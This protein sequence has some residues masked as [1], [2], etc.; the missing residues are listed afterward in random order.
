MKTSPSPKAT[1]AGFTLI[2]LLTVIAIIS[3]LAAMLLPALSKAKA[4]AQGIQC[5]NNLRQLGLAWIM[6]ADDHQG[7]LAPSIAAGHNSGKVPRLDSWVGGAM[8]FDSNFDNVNTGLLI[9][10]GTY[11]HAAKLGPYLKN[12]AIFRC[13]G[14]KSQVEI[15]GRMVNRVRS[16]AMNVYMGNHGVNPNE[17][18]SLWF[19]SQ[20]QLFMRYSDMANPAKYYVFIDEREDSINEG[21]FGVVMEAEAMGDWPASY[22][23]NGGALAFGDGHSELKKWLDPRTRPAKKN[24]GKLDQLVLMPGSS[25]LAWL[26]ERSTSPR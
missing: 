9:D 13:P 5:L 20:Y 25:D 6:Y 2:E 18:I 4:K 7:R 11:P 10:D 26:R 8:S 3:V 21:I 16:V 14:D 19:S 22:H 15:F 23:G 24:W 1:A 17:T 12:S